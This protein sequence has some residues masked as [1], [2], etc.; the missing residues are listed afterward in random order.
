LTATE[1]TVAVGD[2]PR[3]FP[4]PDVLEIRFNNKRTKPHLSGAAI[5]LA[6]G[7]RLAANPETID[8]TKAIVRFAE[9]PGWPS[10]HVPLETIAG[11]ILDM[12]EIAALRS[13]TLRTVLDRKQKTDL[14]DLKNGDQAKGEFLELTKSALR[15][16][17][18][19]GETSIDRD[20]IRLVTM[21][22]ELISVPDL[23]G[24]AMLLA[25]VDGSRITATDVSLDGQDRLKLKALFGAEME[26]P[27][28]AMVSMRCLGGRAVYLSDL[29]PA[30]YAHKPYLAGRWELKTDR[31]VRGEPLFLDG[32]EYPKGLGMH[33]QSQVSYDLKG[34]YQTFRA[35]IG[36]DDAAQGQGSVAFVVEVDG[37]EKYK[38]APQTARDAAV[39]LPSI[40]V[41]GANRLTL[42]VEFAEF[43]DALD[44][45]NWCDAVLIR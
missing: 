27:L 26:L 22:Q 40:S 20:S 21:N 14:V 33:S 35:V 31:N 28:A 8:D 30:Q 34:E 29:D 2:V 9:F 1:I 18:P 13:E 17:S 19:V 12:P 6:N 16:D 37:E 38:S 41:A 15:L 4:T 5:F 23:E 43:G 25:L 7:D 39:N 24:P 10:A 45:A 32:Q 11:F 3:T 36:V 42:K 44:Y